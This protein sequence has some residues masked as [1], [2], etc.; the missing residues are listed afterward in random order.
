MPVSRTDV[1]WAIDALFGV[2]GVEMDPRK[3]VDDIM[4]LAKAYS[5]QDDFVSAVS[6]TV[7]M[8]GRLK[9]GTVDTSSLADDYEG[10]RCCHFQ[11]KTGQGVK[12]RM[13]IMYAEADGTIRVRGFG[14]RG[15]PAD[16]Y[17]RMA[18]IDRLNLPEEGQ[19]TTFPS[20][21]DQAD[22]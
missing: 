8:L 9:D 10:W 12:A 14:E 19:G 13:R 4:G 18:E 11:H 6:S 22:R 17:R 7:R 2:E 5:D 16:F 15:V 21:S 20:D 1:L 3:A